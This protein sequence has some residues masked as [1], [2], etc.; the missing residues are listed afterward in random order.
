MYKAMLSAGK[1]VS[2]MNDS[3]KQAERVR[4]LEEAL[5]AAMAVIENLLDGIRAVASLETA[6]HTKAGA[7]F[8]D[9]QRAWMTIN[10]AVAEA[11]ALIE[12][13]KGGECND[14]L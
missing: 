13:G 2:E 7:S 5:G 12:T 9:I 3:D 11:N 1:V 6:T 4:K 8:K 14:R 10:P